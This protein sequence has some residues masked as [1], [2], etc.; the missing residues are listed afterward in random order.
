MNKRLTNLEHI[1]STKLDRSE[2]T[3]I[4]T[5]TKR[6]E[7]Y[8]GDMEMYSSDITKIKCELEVNSA[9][10]EEMQKQI[11]N[12]THQHDELVSHCRKF[13]LKAETRNIAK[14]LDDCKDEMDKLADKEALTKVSNSGV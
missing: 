9:K 12:L 5:M 11:H 3:C 10:I 4:E 2:L 1:V 7:S 8:I 6:L 14:L 13:A